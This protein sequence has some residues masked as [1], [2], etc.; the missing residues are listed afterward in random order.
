MRA[1]NSG[2]TAYFLQ[3]HDKATA[4]TAGGVPIWEVR[5]PANGDG[6]EDFGLAGL[7]FANGL[8]L[9]ISTTAGTLTFAAAT[10][11]VAYVTYA[12]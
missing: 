4:P 7:Y 6:A 3:I 2:A 12:S 8:G 5:L 1:V 10:D 9:A 11:A